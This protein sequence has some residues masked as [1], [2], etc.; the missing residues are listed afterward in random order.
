LDEFRRAIRLS[1]RVAS[2]LIQRRPIDTL[3]ALD[4]VPASAPS[5]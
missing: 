2:A 5:A 3:A 4:A 1:S